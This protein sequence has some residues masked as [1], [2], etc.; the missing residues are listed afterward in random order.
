MQ[1][2]RG[3]EDN[4]AF[5]AGKNN[6]TTAHGLLTL[7]LKIAR[8]TA[9]SPSAD[10]EMAAI[11]KRQKFNDAIPAGLPK[12]VAVGHKTGSITR[13]QHDAG[14]VYGARPYELVVL[15]RGIEDEKRSKALI[16]DVSRIVWEGTNA[17]RSSSNARP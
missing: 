5:E 10:A 9:V 7:L 1:V 14:I 13:I 17:A 8:G 12:G 15:V 2:L 16:A 11:L 3:V 4:K 6:T